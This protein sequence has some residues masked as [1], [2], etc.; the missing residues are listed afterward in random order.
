M[1][2]S[3]GENRVKGN[4]VVLEKVPEIPQELAEAFRRTDNL[5]IIRR[6]II[7]GDGSLEKRIE[8][9][10]DDPGRHVIETPSPFSNQ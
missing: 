10:N 7:V 5:P 3:E 6:R 8:S 9:I 4:T 2:N 1:S